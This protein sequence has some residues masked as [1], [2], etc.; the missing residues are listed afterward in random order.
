[1]IWYSYDGELKNFISNF[2]SKHK[3][4]ITLLD[5]SNYVNEYG[6]L[7]NKPL[8]KNDLEGLSEEERRYA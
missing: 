6:N 7:V 4:R 1:M 5:F 8:T 2:N 3:D